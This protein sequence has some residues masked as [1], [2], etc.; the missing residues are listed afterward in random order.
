MR[1]GEF[2]NFLG[3]QASAS[4]MPLRG[5]G[6]SLDASIKLG[7]RP[8]IDCLRAI[9]VLAVVACHWKVPHFT[10]GFVGVDVFFVISGF[11]IARMIYT[12][13]LE[14]NFSFIAFYERRIRRIA[15]ALYVVVAVTAITSLIL[16]LPANLIS[17]SRSV[18]AVVTFTSNIL[19]WQ[20]SGY[21]DALEMEKP[22]L[23]TWSLAVEEQ[24][25][26]VIPFFIFLL[27]RYAPKR[28]FI[29]L[30]VG[31]LASSG[32]SIWATHFA[33]SAAFYLAASRAW[34]FL[35]G[36]IL[37][38]GPVPDPQNATVRKIAGTFGIVLILFSVLVHSDRMYFPGLAAIIPC[39]GASLFI[40]AHSGAPA[41]KLNVITPVLVFFGKISY[42][43]YLW[44]WPVI[45]FARNFTDAYAHDLTPA[46]LISIFGFTVLISYLSF[47]YIEQPFRRR[48]I[49]VTRRGLFMYTGIASAFLLML[50]ATGIIFSGFPQRLDP[51]AAKIAEYA[52]YDFSDYWRAR[53][54]FLM[55]QLPADFKVD[56]CA[57][58]RSGAT[59]I[60]I[61]GDS[62]AAHY[63]YGLK[64]IASKDGLNIM[65]A[66]YA[67][68]PPI[69]DFDNDFNSN[70][71]LFNDGVKSV[72]KSRLP[73]AVILSA[74]WWFYIG[75]YGYDA[76]LDDLR[77]TVFQLTGLG[78]KVFLFGPSIEYKRALPTL[79]YRY[80]LVGVDRFNSAQYLNHDI[81]EVDERMN[82]AFSD[83]P[84]VY[85][86]S[87]LKSVCVS[88]TC[89]AVVEDTVPMQ[90]DLQHLTAP[91]SVFVI[92]KLY[93]AISS[94]LGVP[95]P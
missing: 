54:C 34:E 29:W 77:K 44:H 53:T 81:F 55:D 38:V 86:I 8:E 20:E 68:C 3:V 76:I 37:A 63:V 19:F 24:F 78:I 87:I 73:D 61:W 18:I 35:F 11:L 36:A 9:A 69:F 4:D 58:K 13:T 5:T 72:L 26:L 51:R 45:I 60:L 46:H 89:P 82:K 30:S 25:Y 17:F 91:G 2:L 84:N 75:R 41:V 56:E 47:R 32:F 88:D 28:E 74:R 64:E 85:F 52:N 40:W 71:R 14:G 12:E 16:L 70:C 50:G 42:S 6:R 66:T 39:L 27:A 15:P 22:L 10:G 57:S 92:N 33:P 93:P 43:L 21:F 90:F 95:R 49:A 65:Q 83:I 7:Y 67:T 1:R 80:A 79:L 31:A 23:H 94:H 48:E 62:Q 59:N